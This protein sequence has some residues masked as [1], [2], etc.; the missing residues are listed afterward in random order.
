MP[1]KS[2]AILLPLQSRERSSLVLAAPAL[3]QSRERGSMDQAANR[4]HTETTLRLAIRLYFS[5]ES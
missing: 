3:P 5:L 4:Q 1:R 2:R